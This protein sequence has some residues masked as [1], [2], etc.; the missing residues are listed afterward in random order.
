MRTYII[1][2][3]NLYHKVRPDPEP[4]LPHQFL[5][6]YVNGSGLRGSFRN[7]VIVVFDGG[8]VTPLNDHG[9]QVMF[10]KQYSADDVIKGLVVKSGREGEVFVISDDKEV[11]S[12]ARYARKKIYPVSQF[13]QDVRQKKCGAGG[14]INDAVMD[15]IKKDEITRELEK[16]WVKK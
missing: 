12:A 9:F 15:D 10:G 3:F 1:D 14:S 4:K 8:D 16:I 5:L 7:E 2:A 6:D 13:V 11:Q